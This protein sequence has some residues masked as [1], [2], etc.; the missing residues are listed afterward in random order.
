MDIHHI[1]PPREFTVGLGASSIVKDCARISLAAGEQVTFASENG[2]EYDV[3]R[4]DWGYYATPSLNGRLAGFGLRAV[5]VRN[6]HGRFYLLLVEGGKEEAFTAYL[7]LEEQ[8]IVHWLDDDQSLSAL[9]TALGRT[10]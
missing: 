4:T 3:Y 7:K 2:S 1:N 5:L 9:E 6:R 10:A 8:E